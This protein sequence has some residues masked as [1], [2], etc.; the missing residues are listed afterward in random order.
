MAGVIQPN[1]L[2]HDVIAAPPDVYALLSIQNHSIM[3]RQTLEH[4]RM[5]SVEAPGLLNRR[6]SVARLLADVCCRLNGTAQHRSEDNVELEAVLFQE[7]ASLLGL[8]HTFGGHARIFPASELLLEV[9]LTLTMSQEDH[10]AHF[11]VCDA[12]LVV[13]AGES[14]S[15]RAQA[16]LGAQGAEAVLLHKRAVIAELEAKRCCLRRA[17]EDGACCST[18]QVSKKSSQRVSVGHHQN[19]LL[20]CQQRNDVLVPVGHHAGRSHGQRLA[21][22]KLLRRHVLVESVVGRVPRITRVNAF[23]KDIIAATPVLDAILAV[24][25]DG[26]LL[27]EPLKYSGMARIQLPG[28][29]LRHAGVLRRVAHQ[30]SC[31]HRP[32]QNGGE[33]MVKEHALSLE[34]QP[35]LHGLLLAFQGQ[36]GILPTAIDSLG[37]PQTLGVAEEEDLVRGLGVQRNLGVERGGVEAVLLHED[38]V[39]S[40][41]RDFELHDQ[42]RTGW[43]H[44]DVQRCVV[45]YFLQELP[46]SP[47]RVL[48]C[49]HKN[50]L[51]CT[52]ARNDLLLPV[53]HHPPHGARQGLAAR[54]E[55]FR[56]DICVLGVVGGMS[57]IVPIDASRKNVVAASPERDVG[58]PIESHGLRLRQSLEAPRMARIEAPRLID[59]DRCVP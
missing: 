7:A 17:I 37:I 47:Q 18:L 34:E 5:A 23:R 20:T 1:A 33:D 24:H 16:Q 49:R 36:C 30:L 35:S 54:R 38:Q 2:W 43:H 21:T 41:G 55:L 4:A 44:L 42:R 26:F 13:E 32:L 51:A 27:R 56:W 50:R 53:R 11:G 25:V 15:G 22:R 59:G 48:V 57:R 40:D 19:A 46:K 14:Q 12:G 3:L 31:P 58:L 45:R 39:V 6:V 10:L 9:A 28:C 52:D 29:R 8:L